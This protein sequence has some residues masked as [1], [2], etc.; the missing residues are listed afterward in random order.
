MEVW[1]FYNTTKLF[2]CQFFD[3]VFG[4]GFGWSCFLLDELGEEL[5]KLFPKI[6]DVG[7]ACIFGN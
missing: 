4:D 2:L 6:I 5:R 1:Y 3:C 7:P